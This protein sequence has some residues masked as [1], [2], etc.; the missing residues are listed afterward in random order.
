MV[1]L[2]VHLTLLNCTYIQDYNSTVR[3]R[4]SGNHL[5]DYFVV[6]TLELSAHLTKV[7]FIAQKMVSLCALLTLKNVA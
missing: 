7:E 6:K 5:Y 1:K 4:P 2:K 3:G